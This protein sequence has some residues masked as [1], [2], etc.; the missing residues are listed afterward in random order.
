VAAGVPVIPVSLH[1]TRLVLRDG[2]RLPR[3][4]PT[5]AVGGAPITAPAG[6][7]A[8]AA[9][10]HLRDTARACILGHCGEPDLT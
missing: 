5:R 2:Q 3:R 1:G 7:G 8:F 6:E 9:A 4:A 10:V